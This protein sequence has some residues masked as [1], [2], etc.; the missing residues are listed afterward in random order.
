[1]KN[2]PLDHA[3]LRDALTYENINEFILVLEGAKPCLRI[4]KSFIDTNLLSDL[5]A[6]YGVY[7]LEKDFDNFY[8]SG[9][10]ITIL[11]LALKQEAAELAYE[12][13]RKEE[14][15]ELGKRLGY[16]DCCVEFFYETLR[17]APPET[18]ITPRHIYDNSRDFDLINNNLYNFNGRKLMVAES[19]PLE[20]YRWH[21]VTHE[22]CSYDC[23]ASIE[24]GQEYLR[25]LKGYDPDFVENIQILL[26]KP[27]LWI[28]PGNCLVF[29]GQ[30]EGNIMTYQKLDQQLSYVLETKYLDH[31]LAA[32]QIKAEGREVAFL[33]AGKKIS[34]LELPEEPIWLHFHK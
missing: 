21:I 11:Y 13:E 32:D 17:S 18:G 24:L 9:E 26:A 31:A 23:P 7:L 27:A 19:H 33:R 2:Y 1:M 3:R 20:F 16:P 34:S 14:R 12:A 15:L 30:K 25:I 4:H 6:E 5:C 28:D 22:P 10:K 29:D 8:G